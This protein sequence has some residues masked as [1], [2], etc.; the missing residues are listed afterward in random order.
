[1]KPETDR[2]IARLRA[3]VATLRAE[4]AI[5]RAELADWRAEQGPKRT[6]GEAAIVPISTPKSPTTTKDLVGR[7]LLYPL[8]EAAQMLGVSRPTIYS[9]YHAGNL[10]IVRVGGR[11]FVTNAELERY[12]TTAGGPPHTAQGGRRPPPKRSP[13][14]VSLAH[15]VGPDGWAV[16]AGELPTLGPMSAP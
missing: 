7:R 12:A 5:L 9:L 14:G 11:S 6:T 2:S 16:P 3:E 1:M 8:K 15:C 4:V 13:A 10:E